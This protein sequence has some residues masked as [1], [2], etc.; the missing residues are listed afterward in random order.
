M[1][2]ADLTSHMQQILDKGESAAENR[3]LGTVD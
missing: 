2:P 3:A 1:S